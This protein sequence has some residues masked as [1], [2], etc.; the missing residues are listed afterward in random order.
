MTNARTAKSARDKAAELRAQAARQEARRRSFIALGIVTLVVIVIVG[1]FVLVRNTKDT[2]ADEVTVPAGVTSTGAIVV[3]QASAPVTLTAYED[4]QCP[5]CRQFEQANAAQIQQWVDAGTVKVEYQPIAFLDR[6]STSQYSTR[7]LNVAAAVVNSK[8]AAFPAFHRLL[9]ENQPEEGTAGLSNAKLRSLATQAGAPEA[10]ITQAIEK[11]TYRAWAAKVTE[12][13]SKA[14]VNQTPTL[15][16]NGT[17][18]KSSEPAAVK[19][20]VEAA[21]TAAAKK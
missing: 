6:A 11:G 12:D 13:A 8:P 16:V 17:Q 15:K 19:Q 10:A 14:G 2:S 5:A 9:F 7:A 1:S 4:F 18:L 21:A 20:A 3:G